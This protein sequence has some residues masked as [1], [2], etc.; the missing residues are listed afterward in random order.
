MNWNVAKEKDD[1]DFSRKDDEDVMQ[2]VEI[3]K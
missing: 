3:E 1:Y 2:N